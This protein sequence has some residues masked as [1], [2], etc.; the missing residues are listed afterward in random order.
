MSARLFLTSAIFP[1]ATSG[2]GYTITDATGATLAA[3]TT[4][5][6]TE[7]PVG[8]GKF[9]ARAALDSSW[10]GFIDWDDGNGNV[11]SDRFE[12]TTPPTGTVAPQPRRP[13]QFVHRLGSPSVLT[14]A[15]SV[16]MS[17]PTNTF[18][19]RN[20]D[21]GAIVVPNN[22]PMT[23]VALGSYFWDIIEPGGNIE[24]YAKVTE[25]ALNGGG[26]FAYPFTSLDP[27]VTTHYATR[28]QLEVEY[29]LDDVTTYANLQSNDP[30]TSLTADEVT[31]KIER[32]LTFADDFI[33]SRLRAYDYAIPLVALPG[34]TLPTGLLNTIALCLAIWRLYRGRGKRDNDKVGDAFQ[35]DY[36]WAV[37]ELDSLLLAGLPAVQDTDADLETA[38]DAPI[39]V[40]ATVDANGCNLDTTCNPCN[41]W[42]ALTVWR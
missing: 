33:N 29:G 32:A 10:T 8:T 41:R 38:Q 31:A 11:Q 22:T 37:K 3:R 36:D 39:A 35:E 24:W 16:V 9:I 20:I 28:A 6:V 42:P 25:T 1:G 18:G 17:D 34:A 5:G 27:T 21:T 7:S 4:V 15:A 40:A 19:A 14:D 23:R 30:A 12:G 26:T 2:I 13:F